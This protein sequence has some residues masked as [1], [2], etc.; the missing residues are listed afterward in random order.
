LRFSAEA[1]SHID[2]LDNASIMARNAD[3]FVL[4]MTCVIVSGLVLIF[5]SRE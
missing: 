3:T 5:L 4:A 1:Y 2:Q